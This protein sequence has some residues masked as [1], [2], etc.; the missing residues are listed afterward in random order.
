M[1]EISYAVGLNMSRD[2]SSIE[3][4]HKSKAALKWFDFDNGIVHI[5]S[6]SY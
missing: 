4:K 6:K 3:E 5:C 1:E 2:Y